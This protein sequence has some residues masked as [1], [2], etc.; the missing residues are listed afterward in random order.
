MSSQSFANSFGLGVVLGM[1]SGISANYHLSERNSLDAALSL[2]ST[3]DSKFYF[4]S[5]YLVHYR[6]SL[7]VDEVL[8]GWYYGIGAKIE[9]LEKRNKDTNN[10]ETK[11]YLGPRG[12]IGLNLP[13]Q[14]DIDFDIFGEITLGLDVI[15]STNVYTGIGI[16]GR[17]YF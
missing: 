12:S 2:N 4:H 14:K 3:G 1:P 7:K 15:P 17:I 5:T 9:N 13:L 16:G 11:T 6:N 10:E 8:L